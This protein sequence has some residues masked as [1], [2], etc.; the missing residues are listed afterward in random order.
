VAGPT[1]LVA[2]IGGDEFVL[3]CPDGDPDRLAA[4]ADRV[5]REIGRPIAGPEC[6][7]SVGVSVGIAI[8]LPGEAPDELVVRA[9]RAMYGAKSRHTRRSPREH[10]VDD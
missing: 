1:D 10:P 5:R 9:D 6:E 2:R 4:L 8:G 7:L 3:V